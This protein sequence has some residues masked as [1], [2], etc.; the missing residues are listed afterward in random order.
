MADCGS[1]SLIADGVAMPFPPC[2]GPRSA[3]EPTDDRSRLRAFLAREWFSFA[4]L[5]APQQDVVLDFTL[6]FCARTEFW[7]SPGLGDQ[8][9]LC[10]LVGAAAALVGAAQ[11]T[12][13]FADVRWVYLLD[14]DVLEDDKS[15]DA[16][17]VSTVRINAHDLVHESRQCIPGQQVAIHE[18]AHVLDVMFGLSGGSNGLKEGLEKHLANCRDGIEDLFPEAVA[19]ALMED[20]A[21]VEF[22]AYASEWFFTDPVTLHDF[23]APLYADLVSIYGLDPTG[24]ETSNLR[25]RR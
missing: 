17:G 22:F 11:P 15:G 9:S 8:E 21:D 23:H 6:T 19:D 13:C 16:L 2:P 20:N 5:T 25:S 7:F 4:L 12:A 14:D 10:W 3:V 18:F 1:S 24:F